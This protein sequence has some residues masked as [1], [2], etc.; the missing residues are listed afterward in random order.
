MEKGGIGMFKAVLSTTVLP[1]DGIYEVKTLAPADL[2]SVVGVPHYIGHP[3]T[4]EIVESLGAVQSESR[5]FTGLA[6][7]EKA[8][9]FPI[10]QGKSSRIEEGKTV[11]Q[12]VSL[13]DLSVRVITRIDSGRKCT[14]C[15]ET[16]LI[17]RCCPNCGAS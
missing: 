17:S 10:Q 16:D 15:G 12:T 5:L 7:G 6:P 8:V 3:A 1:L 11:D 14:F 13:A 4:R 2:P 9:C